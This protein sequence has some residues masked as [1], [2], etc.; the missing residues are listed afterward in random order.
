MES[1]SETLDYLGFA[2]D[3]AIQAII[4]QGKFI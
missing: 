1:T 3:K 2:G 4:Q